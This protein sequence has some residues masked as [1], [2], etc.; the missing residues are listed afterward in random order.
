M[1]YSNQPGTQE[2]LKT[3]DKWG[4]ARAHSAVLG[5]AVLNV[6]FTIMSLVRVR[7]RRWCLH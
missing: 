4:K 2:P 3:G 6:L 5:L 7:V 1:A